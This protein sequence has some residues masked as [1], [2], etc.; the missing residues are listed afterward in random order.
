MHISKKDVLW[1]YAA[2]FLKIAASILLLPI[3]L[4]KMPSEMVAIWSVFMTITAFSTLLDFGFSPSFTRNVTYIFS[5][6]KSLQK[7]GF[8]VV[9]K[10]FATIDY[11]LLKGIISAMR[12]IYLRMAVF[13]FIIL[14]SI[15]TYYIYTLL[16]NY[17]GSHQ[18]VYI[19]WGILCLINTYNLYTLYYD[20]LLQGKGLIKK[21]KQIIIIGQIAYLLIASILIYFGKGLIAIVSAQAASVLLIRWLSHKVFFSK[22]MKNILKTAIEKKSK[23]IINV[24]LPN[25]L[26]IGSSTLCGFV[27]QKS[28]IIVGSLYLPLNDIAS[29]GITL[30]IIA[31]IT[32][33]SG[34]YTTTYLPKI[35]H[36]RVMQNANSIKDVYL[37]GEVLLVAIF[38]VG[39]ATLLFLGQ[40]TLTLIGSHTPL[41]PFLMLAFA[42]LISFLES[43]HSLAGII[44]L[45]KNEVPFFK[46]SILSAG[47]T[48]LLLI[49]FLQNTDMGIWAMI[50]APGI[51]QGVYQ[52][53]KWPLVVS[54]DL[55]I[56]KHDIVNAIKSVST[57]I[58]KKR[59]TL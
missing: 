43:N 11:G 9:D 23:E 33:L 44:I 14:S 25:A 52:N 22:E 47:F 49:V 42:I 38:L 27:I 32:S 40:W 56:T 26:K 58:L 46:A 34:I 41:I 18:E 20:S 8:E 24:I 6:V 2:T 57:Y 29:Y 3:I 4:R 48:I 39:G 19:A 5:G 7:K 16:K 13:L 50:L 31:V 51:A 35:I 1:N 21:S 30:Q 55:A 28:S 10:H 53:W 17:S 45:T 12:W 54:K 36:S 37:K 15:G 59:N